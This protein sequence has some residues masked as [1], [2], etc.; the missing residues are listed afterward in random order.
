MDEPEKES[1]RQAPKFDGTNY[2]IWRVRFK[3]W[4]IERKLWEFFTGSKPRPADDDGR[5]EWDTRNQRAYMELT[6]SITD[7]LMDHIMPFE[8]GGEGSEPGLRIGARDRGGARP[9]DAWSKVDKLCYEKGKSRHIA[10]RKQLSSLAMKK[11]EKVQE[12]WGRAEKM[13]REL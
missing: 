3:G 2:D 5:K 12:Y 1:R 7:K 10:L 4:A 13:R 11:G 8:I 9:S 6:L